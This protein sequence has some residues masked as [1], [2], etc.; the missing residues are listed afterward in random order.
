MSKCLAGAS[1]LPNHRHLPHHHDAPQPAPCLYLRGASRGGPHRA[2]LAGGGRHLRRKWD[3]ALH[4]VA[5]QLPDRPHGRLLRGRSQG[6]SH[7]CGGEKL[8]S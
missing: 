4:R 8:H 7:H 2:P 6:H 1:K 3:M 5:P